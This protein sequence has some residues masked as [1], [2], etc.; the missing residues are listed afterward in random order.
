MPRRNELKSTA[1]IE[2]LVPDPGNLNLGTE[3]GRALLAASL[4]A[5]GTD[6]G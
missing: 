4:K 6:D 1:G 5:H 2:D 3:R